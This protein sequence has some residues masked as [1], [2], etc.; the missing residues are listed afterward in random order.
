MHTKARPHQVVDIEALGTARRQ[1]LA[2]LIKADS[3]GDI[4]LNPED[5][6]QA[7]YDA[8]WKVWRFKYNDHPWIYITDQRLRSIAIH[9]EAINEFNTYINTNYWRY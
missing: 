5:L 9:Q 7:L 1:R 8:H 6:E 4:V 3:F 2:Q